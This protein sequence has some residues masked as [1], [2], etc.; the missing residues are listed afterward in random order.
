M[1]PGRRHLHGPLGVLLPPDVGKVRRRRGGGRREGQFPGGRQLLPPDEV[2]QYL[3]GGGHGVD[4]DAGDGGPLPAVLHGEEHPLYPRLAGGQH[5]G[6][7]PPH[8]PQPPV[9]GE[10]PRK[11]AAG[12]VHVALAGGQQQPQQDG[13]VVD[14]PR[15][16]G[17][18]GGQ[19]HQNTAVRPGKAQ[20][21][22]GGAHPLPRL[23]DGG[24]GQPHQVELGQ[25]PLAVH[26][27]RHHVPLDA[28]KPHGKDRRKHRRTSSKKIP[29]LL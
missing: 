7:R 29:P 15:L 1:P 17:V 28:R 8:R 16:F 4:S 21:P 19:V 20:V 26:L 13:E 23:L 22:G 14:G 18:G 11:G 2:I 3:P 5:H 27:H 9:Q 12:K 25:P 10:L 24:V 6:Q